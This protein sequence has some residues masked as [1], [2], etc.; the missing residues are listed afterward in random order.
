M[1]TEKETAPQI[2][3][4]KYTQVGKKLTSH[5]QTPICLQPINRH[6]EVS[7]HGGT[8]KASIFI[9]FSII[10]PH[11]FIDPV[12]IALHWS[13]N[14]LTCNSTRGKWTQWK[15]WFPWS[16]DFFLSRGNFQDPKL[17]IDI[18]GINRYKSKKRIQNWIKG[19]KQRLQA[20]FSRSSML[21]Q[22]IFALVAKSWHASG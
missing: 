5:S 12:R 19:R 11:M 16:F 20:P 18:M 14:P 9:G 1:L 6:M 3:P 10:N 17:V 7:W 21:P 15:S 13:E 22:P 2:W 4:V 8:S